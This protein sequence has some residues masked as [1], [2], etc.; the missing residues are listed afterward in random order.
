MRV[1]VAGAV[2][3]A[4]VLPAGVGAQSLMLSESD[5][6]A[7]LSAD[8]P[9][10]RAI[11]AGVDVARVDVLS[12]G[13]WP[14]PRVNWDRQSVAGIAENLVTVAQVLPITGR[15]GLEVQAASARVAASGHRIDDET[16]RLRGDLRLAFADLQ[17]AQMRERELTTA[18]DRLRELTEILA[19]REAEGD[20]AGFDRLRA[21]REVLDV[22]ADMVAATTERARAQATLAAFFS[23]VTDSSRIVAVPRSA[24]VAPEAQPPSLAE[25]GATP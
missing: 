20:A 10:M 7:R 4:V 23:D 17:A 13:R 18:R 5:A 24:P 16:R 11:R 12:A 21:E 6:L 3:A 1:F 22:E 2:L 9:R 8:S 15:R 19:K 25:A 14:N